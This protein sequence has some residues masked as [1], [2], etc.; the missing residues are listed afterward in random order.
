[1]GKVFLMSTNALRVADVNDVHLYT[2]RRVEERQRWEQSLMLCVL[3][4]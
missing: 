3:Q 2:E 1:M 4:M